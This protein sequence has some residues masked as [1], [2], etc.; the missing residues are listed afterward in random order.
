MSS[1]NYYC[2][3]CTEKLMKN[4]KLTIN[5]MPQRSKCSCAKTDKHNI[6]SMRCFIC[7]KYY[8]PIEMYKLHIIIN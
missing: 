8:C 1:L 4:K 7:Y 2:Q 6:P 5:E 3:N